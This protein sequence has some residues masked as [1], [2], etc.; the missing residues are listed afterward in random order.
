MAIKCPVNEKFAS[1]IICQEISDSF[2]LYLFMQQIN[3][4]CTDYNIGK[5]C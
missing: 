3:K 4:V 2:L 5:I 1:K